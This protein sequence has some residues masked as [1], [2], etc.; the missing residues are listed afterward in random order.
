MVQNYGKQV[1]HKTLNQNK[2]VTPSNCSSLLVDKCWFQIP[3]V[4]LEMF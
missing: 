1:E 3:H 4:N 2:F